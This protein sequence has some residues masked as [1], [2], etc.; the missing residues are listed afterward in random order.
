MFLNIYWI[1]FFNFFFTVVLQEDMINSL[2]SRYGVHAHTECVVS[3]VTFVTE[4]HLILMM[5]L[6]THGAGLT[7]HTLPV[8]RLDNTNQFLTHVQ[9]GWV[10]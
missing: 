2:T 1:F 9:T 3:S 4:H 6:L 5:G 7:L 10:A 8:V